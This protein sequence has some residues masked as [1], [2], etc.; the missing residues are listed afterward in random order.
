[1]RARR[2]ASYTISAARAVSMRS[3]EACV[4]TG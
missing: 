1:V 2:Q 4:L 3:T